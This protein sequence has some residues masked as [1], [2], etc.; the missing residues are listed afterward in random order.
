M[1]I[2]GGENIDP[3]EIE[4]LAATW[5]GVAEA[6]VVGLPDARWGEAPVLVLVPQA[7][8]LVDVAGLQALLTQRLARFKQP[9]QVLLRAEMPRTA[10]GKVQKAV[11]VRL[12]LQGSGPA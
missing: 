2:S 9:R 10:L 11:L 1:L 12:L 3:A 6:V 5:P 4:N 7:G 8:A